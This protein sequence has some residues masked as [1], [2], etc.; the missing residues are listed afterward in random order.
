VN[1]PEQLA[2]IRLTGLDR[3]DAADLEDVL[4]EHALAPDELR[5]EEETLPPHRLGEPVTFILL[6]GITMATIGVLGAFLMKR[7]TREA[8]RYSVEV[9]YPDGTRKVEVLELSRNESEAPDPEVIEK[10]A[11][12]TRLPADRVSALLGQGG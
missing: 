9:T 7:R 2:T 1:E 6:A 8:L 3:A 4:A 12:I 10:L 5:I 11:E